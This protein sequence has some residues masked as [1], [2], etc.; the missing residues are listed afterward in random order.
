MRALLYGSKVDRGAKARARVGLAILAFAVVYSIIAAAARHVCGRS[1]RPHRASRRR[2]RRDRDG[3]SGHPRSQRRDSGDRRAR[4]LALRRAAPAHRCRR[5]GGIAHRR[6]ARSRRH[7]TAR[8]ALLQARL[9]LA[10]A[11][12][13][14]GAAARNLPPGPARHRLPERKQAQTIRTAPRSRISSATS[15]STTRASPA[16]RSGSTATASPRCTWRGLPPTGCKL[17][18]SL[19]SIC[20]C[21]MRCATSSSPRAP[22]SRRSPP[23]A[24]FSTC[25]PARSSP[26]CRSRITTPTIRTR[27]SIRRASIG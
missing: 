3:A 22:N 15:I 25:A 12:H 6:P 8:A 5:G 4:A 11:R 14:A 26:W 19:P 10:Q 21:S 18:C 24:S 1:R 13:H 17:R 27:R 23:P 20:A 2:Q 9:R 16:W 7:R